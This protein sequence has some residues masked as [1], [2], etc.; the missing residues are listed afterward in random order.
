MQ[1]EWL[2]DTEIVVNTFCHINY[3]KFVDDMLTIL[4]AI[5]YSVSYGGANIKVNKTLIE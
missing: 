2:I 1:F 4:L 3:D 5:R